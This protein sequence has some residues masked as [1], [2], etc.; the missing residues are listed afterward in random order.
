MAQLSTVSGIEKLNASFAALSSNMQASQ[1]LQA[2]NM[3][4]HGVMTAGE[5]LATLQREGD[6]RCGFTAGC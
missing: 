1:N 4:G 3:I 6:L 5:L 2:A